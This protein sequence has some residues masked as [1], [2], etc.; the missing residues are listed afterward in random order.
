MAALFVATHLALFTAASLDPEYSHEEADGH[1]S[2]YMTKGLRY[3]VYVEVGTPP[4][5]WLTL[6][7]TRWTTPVKLDR[8]R[9]GDKAVVV[10]EGKTY[11]WGGAFKAPADDL[12]TVA[13]DPAAGPQRVQVDAPGF[14]MSVVLVLL[15]PLVVLTCLI[16]TFALYR[17]RRRPKGYW[18]TRPSSPFLEVERTKQAEKARAVLGAHW[19]DGVVLANGTLVPGTSEE[20]AF[21]RLSDLLATPAGVPDA[22]IRSVEDGGWLVEFPSHEVAVFVT[23]KDV[24][25]GEYTD[26]MRCAVARL[27]LDARNRALAPV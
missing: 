6:T 11:V 4:P 22:R 20:Q 23:A 10:G 13:A 9:H 21:D 19:T 17:R 18:T 14:G 27:E 1:A 12:V 25:S 16:W 8:K 26:V 15:T 2:I 7:G 5:A 3:T 24:K